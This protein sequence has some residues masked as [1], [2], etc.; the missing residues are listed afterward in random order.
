[1]KRHH[2]LFSWARRVAAA[3]AS[4]FL[5]NTTVP[6]LFSLR[7]IDPSKEGVWLNNVGVL[8]LCRGYGPM[9]ENFSWRALMDDECF[10]GW[11]HAGDDLFTDA[12]TRDSLRFSFHEGKQNIFFAGP[13]LNFVRIILVLCA[14]DAQ[15][16]P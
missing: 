5:F 15:R 2:T 3:S 9:F 7:Q 14:T 13:G 16:R 10:P 11:S 8:D 4:L 6:L 1:M 12:E